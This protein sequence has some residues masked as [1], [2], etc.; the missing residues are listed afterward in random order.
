MAAKNPNKE[1]AKQIWLEHKGDIT[2]RKIAEL[3]GED[4]K[5]IAVWKGRDR[6]GKDDVVQQPE[7]RCTT[8]NRK[9]SCQSSIAESENEIK[10]SEGQRLFCHYF[11]KEKNATQAALMA[12]Y[13][14]SSAHVEGSRLLRNDKVRAEIKR[15]K[16]NTLEE[17]MIDAMDVL[18]EYANIAF[19]DIGNYAT[20]EG[21]RVRIKSMDEVDTSVISEIKETAFGVSIKLHNKMK[22]LEKLEKYFDLLPDKFKR[23]LDQA[24]LDLDQKR[25][26]F[27]EQPQVEDDGFIDALKAPVEGLWDKEVAPDG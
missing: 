26:G 6:W 19:A 24:R 13:A 21:Y 23:Q 14:K 8:K 18:Q 1:K 9:K 3:I 7:K 17:L 10:L 20:T 15:L 5:K 2:N 4:E 22:A 11:V 25:A 16:G 27:G 12:G